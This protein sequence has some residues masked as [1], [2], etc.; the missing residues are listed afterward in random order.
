MCFI[1][2]ARPSLAH[3]H[4]WSHHSHI[5]AVHCVSLCILCVCVRFANW[6]IFQSIM[7]WT[8]TVTSVHCA[9]ATDHKQSWSVGL[10]VVC[11]LCV[12]PMHIQEGTFW[13]FDN[14]DNFVATL[15]ECIFFLS[16]TLLIL[17]FV[18]AMWSISIGFLQINQSTRL[19][20]FHHRNCSC[21]TSETSR[22]AIKMEL[23][24]WT[25]AA[26]WWSLVVGIG[27]Q[28]PLAGCLVELTLC[29]NV[30]IC[31]TL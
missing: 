17:G 7:E 1:F 22:N 30:V 9:H 12:C 10:S 25:S 14:M 4:F 26:V 28:L 21:S 19:H 15:I 2:K 11:T 5:D 8:N 6:I 13:P 18:F 16:F 23:N 24:K 29:V 3:I 27:C 31:R 20:I